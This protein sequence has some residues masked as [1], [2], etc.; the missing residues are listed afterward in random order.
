MEQRMLRKIKALADEN[1]MKI[2]QLILEKNFCVNALARE[3]D[4]SESA[5]SQHLKI[6][7]EA[8]LVIGEK[9]GY[10]VHYSVKRDNLLTVADF[11]KDLAVEKQSNCENCNE[12]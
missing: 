8:N 12:D 2:L 5:I 9:K 3:L 11:I 7:R 1:R 10:Y 4:I 6:L